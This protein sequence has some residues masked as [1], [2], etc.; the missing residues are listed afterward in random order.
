MLQP[1]ATLATKKITVVSGSMID[2][3]HVTQLT[4]TLSNLNLQSGST[5]ALSLTNAIA[6]PNAIKVAASGVANT[7]GINYTIRA[8]GLTL[9]TGAT[10]YTIISST[11]IPSGTPGTI[12]TN[13]RHYDAT[14]TVSST[15]VKIHVT[16]NTAT[17][18]TLTST[19]SGRSISP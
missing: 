11:G 13:M 4:N 19:A 14:A 1:S 7:D 8:K 15:A 16:A 9:D 6:D 3:G 5:L 2:I 17:A 18:K 10:G 12:T